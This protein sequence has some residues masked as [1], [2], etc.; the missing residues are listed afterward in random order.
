MAKRVG[1]E[2][3]RDIHAATRFDPDRL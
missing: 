3:L 2:L 1:E